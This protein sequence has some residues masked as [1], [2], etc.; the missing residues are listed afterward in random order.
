MDGYRVNQDLTLQTPSEFSDVGGN[1]E[2][3]R[4]TI[5]A[6]N[7]LWE[8]PHDGIVNVFQPGKMDAYFPSELALV[9]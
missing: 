3:R 6:N 4:A 8:N 1:K 5:R 2:F 7:K 9:D